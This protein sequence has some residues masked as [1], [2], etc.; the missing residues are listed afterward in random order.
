[1]G[2]ETIT[3][4]PERIA[5]VRREFEALDVKVVQQFALVGPYDFL[6]VVEA[7]HNLAVFRAS[8]EQET[9]GRT[10]TDVLPA[11]DV[12]LFVR[13]LGQTTETVGPYPWQISL[14]ARLVR[15]C[16][17]YHTITRYVWKHCRPFEV[18]GRERLDGLAN[19]AIFIGNHAS[20]MDAF[21]LFMALPERF[22]RRVA[23]G[24]AAD[25]WFL[26]GRKGIQKQPWYMTLTM[27]SFPIQRGGGRTA[28]GYAEWLLDRRWSLVIFP[29]GTRSTTGKLAPFRH[30][31][32][33]LAL[34][35]EVP[36]VPIYMHGLRELRPKGSKE[37]KV[38]PVRVQIGE[39]IR[40]A[41]GT[42]LSDATRTLYK[43]ME[44]M[45]E[46][47]RGSPSAPA[48]GVAAR[49]STAHSRKALEVRTSRRTG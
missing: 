22:R 43:T 46:E 14:W 2:F 42:E 6:T 44:R 40:F 49:I 23:F 41:P 1:E 27:N 36:V 20:H 19:P 15:R 3:R 35:K 29:E 25:R 13:L 47:L 32:S 11:I 26:K 4:R 24:S 12:D 31:V 34:A 33:I 5:E 39:P 28:L 8:V 38:G 48:V 10:R 16:L 30:G 18:E 21:V 37:I 9:H 45:R 7:P 17:R